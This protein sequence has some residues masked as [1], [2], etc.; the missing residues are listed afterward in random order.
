MLGKRSSSLHGFCHATP[1]SILLHNRCRRPQSSISKHGRDVGCVRG[2]E[3]AYLFAAPI[4][5]QFSLQ[6]TSSLATASA[7]AP[8]LLSQSSSE[9]YSSAEAALSL[10]M[11]KYWS[12]FARFGSVSCLPSSSHAMTDG[13]PHTLSLQ[14]LH[15]LRDPNG[16]AARSSDHA[17]L[18]AL[19]PVFETTDQQYLLF[20]ANGEL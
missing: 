9:R 3:L 11:I 8:A 1:W 4:L 2:E 20:G 6:A 5:S 19:W 18:P 12:N 14:S 15:L 16:A 13:V 17:S 10:H 7:S